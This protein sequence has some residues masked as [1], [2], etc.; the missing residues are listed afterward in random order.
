VFSIRDDKEH[1]ALKRP[2]ANAYS[3][4]ALVELEPMT[5][6]CIAIIQGKLDSKQGQEID[7]GEWLQWFS[8]D[9][10]TS[11][12]FSNRIGFMEQEKDVS[13]II[14]AIEGRLAYNSVIGE[15][16]S[17]NRFLLGNPFVESLASYIPAL[18]RLNSARF[19]VAFAAKQLDRYKSSGKSTEQLRD[20]LARFKRSR[21]GEEVMSEKELLS[22]AS[23]NVFVFPYP[24]V[25]ARS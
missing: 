18:A 23:S 17:L 9:V 5:D 25:S 19:I 21:D 6:D 15:A 24:Q 1:K 8:F 3:M 16:P 22:H 12:T 14:N 10:I 20:M 11:I 2:V 7:F 4:S 13:G